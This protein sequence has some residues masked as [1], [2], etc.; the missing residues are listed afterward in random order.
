MGVYIENLKGFVY[1]I[2]EDKKFKS[3]NI[4]TGDIMAGIS[5]DDSIY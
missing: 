2:G 3:T 1:S 4:A 5:S